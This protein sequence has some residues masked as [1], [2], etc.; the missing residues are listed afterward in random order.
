MGR[1]TVLY[2]LQGYSN[3][4]VVLFVLKSMEKLSA[5]SHKLR[6]VLKAL[7]DLFVLWSVVENSGSFLEVN[8]FT[9]ILVLAEEDIDAVML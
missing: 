1:F 8:C 6:L 9:S 3:Y 4:V 2:S 7:A 5:I